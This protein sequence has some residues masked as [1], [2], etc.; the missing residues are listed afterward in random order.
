MYKVY[1]YTN[2]KFVVAMNNNDFETED[3]AIQAIGW[4]FEVKRNDQSKVFLI[5]DDFNVIRIIDSQYYVVGY[6]IDQAISYMEEDLRQ[7]EEI[8][9]NGN[10]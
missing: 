8:I 7:Q 2:G 10:S 9:R 5:V 6:K 4:W 1:T 3:A